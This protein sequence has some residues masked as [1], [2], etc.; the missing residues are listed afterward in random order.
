MTLA[1]II[2]I[3]AQDPSF[4]AGM[5]SNEIWY[6]I[7]T[8]TRLTDV[9]AILAQAIQGKADPNHTHDGYAAA[10]HTHTGFAAAEHTHTG[11]AAE[12]HSH[13]GF[14]AEGHTHDG[15]ATSDHTHDYAAPNHTHTPASIGA[16][17]SNHSHSGYAAAN[18]THD[19]AA[20]DHTHTGFA[21]SSHTHTP[22]SIGAAAANH[23]HTV[24]SAL[25]STSTN[26]VQNKAV[27]AALAGKAAASH[28][29][30][31]AATNHT[32]TPASIGAA[33]ASH[34]HD[35]L[36]TSGGTVNGDV[37]VVGVVRVKGQQ[38]IFD[39]GTRQTFGSGNREHY[40]I[41]TKLYCNQ[42]WS[43][44]SDERLKEGIEDADVQA[45]I[46]FISG[47][48]VKTF[49]YIGS[50]VPCMGVIA[51]DIEQ[52]QLAK[53]F[54]SAMDCEEKYLAVRASDMLFPLIVAFQK[55]SQRVAELEAKIR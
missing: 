28:T 6:G 17:A 4:I 7:D 52:S 34:T 53:F 15:Y 39:N 46:D 40:A 13:T 19:Y 14:A 51:Q 38:A 41:G 1:E 30:S 12:N 44:A 42:N 55:L 18:H 25:S 37:N 20:G 9:C 35:Y 31:Y 2:A 27:H 3:A 36:P 32:H 16:A 45:C 54:V 48:D 5:S 49:N 8:N 10:E 11:F 26:P 33:A 22:A 43:V 24:D 21:A 47:I 23:S 29:H 50:D